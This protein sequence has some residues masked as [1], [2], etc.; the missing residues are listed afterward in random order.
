[1]KQTEVREARPG[2]DSFPGAAPLAP[3]PR[4]GP[5][6][7]PSEPLLVLRAVRGVGRWV[8]AAVVTLA[9][10]YLLGALVVPA[11]ITAFARTTFYPTGGSIVLVREALSDAVRAYA[12][13]VDPAITAAEAGLTVSA[14]ELRTPATPSNG[15]A[16]RAVAPVPPPAWRDRALAA[17]LFPTARPR[18]GGGLPY[19]RAVLDAVRAGITPAE[20]AALRAIATDPI[21]REVDRVARAG[22]VDL[23]GGRLVV[24]FPGEAQIS[25]LPRWRTFI[26]GTIG[27]A[28]VSRA[29][30]HLAEGRRD[31]AIAAL[32][33][34]IAF[35]RAIHRNAMFMEEAAAGGAIVGEAREALIKLFELTGDPRA[36]ALRDAVARARNAVV[37]PR[38]MAF[39]P[40][41]PDFDESRTALLEI[42]RNPQMPRSLRVDALRNVN[43]Q[44]CGSMREVMFGPRREVRDAFALA[45]EQLGRFPSERAVLDLIER[46]LSQGAATAATRGVP[47]LE[48]AATILGR[49]YFNP[50][51]ASCTP[52]ALGFR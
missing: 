10:V 5:G 28:S 1:M 37:V 15:F 38:V 7:T 49:L 12:V 8:R 14:L 46:E 27:G 32:G 13:P 6:I 16:F 40:N 20:R 35:G 48:R 9:A 22:A 42:A 45:R 21:W 4:T 19:S 41:R 36:A 18:G 47:Q 17:D 2:A 11:T 33:S 44:T 31:S 3:R 30:W 24:P 34:A 50:R 29:A 23:V 39:T 26:S 43:L 51:I 52:V 25:S